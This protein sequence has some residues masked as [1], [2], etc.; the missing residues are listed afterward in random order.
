MITG[1]SLVN[2]H[3][4]DEWL[5]M[6]LIDADDDGGDDGGDGDDYS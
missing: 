5:L 4:W 2:D 3:E 6:R 1:L